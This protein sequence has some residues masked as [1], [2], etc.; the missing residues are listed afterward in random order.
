MQRLNL[1]PDLEWIDLPRD[2]RVQ[3]QPV[4]TAL[5]YAARRDPAIAALPAD[6]DQELVALVMGQSIARLA[7]VAWEGIGDAEG[8]PI[9][10]SPEA[11]TELMNIWP[12]CRAFNKLIV[13]PAFDQ[14]SEKKG[15]AP[16]PSGSSAAARDTAKDA[17]NSAP[18]APDS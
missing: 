12:I 1:T 11:V 17:G 16:S 2:V 10:P 6:A 3:V 4:T 8:N 18:N 15:S 14:E 5:I 13:E 9:D 7:I